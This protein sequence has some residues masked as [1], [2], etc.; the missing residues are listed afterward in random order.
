MIKSD[1]IIVDRSPLSSIGII[2]CTAP[3]T[4]SIDDLTIGINNNNP[5]DF[6]GRYINTDTTEKVY[7]YCFTIYDENNQVFETSG[8]KIH[9]SNSDEIIDQKYNA[10]DTWTLKKSLESNKLYRITYSIT[11]INGYKMESSPYVIRE[12]N[13]VD[14]NIPAKLLATLDPDNGCVS[15]RLIKPK[16]HREETAFSGNFMISRYSENL[17][18]WN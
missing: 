1:L 9:N 6:L 18:T 5:V 12:A 4:L 11:T 15:L 14:A 13:T 2:K 8:E 3:I 7:S 16:E 10:I 17:N